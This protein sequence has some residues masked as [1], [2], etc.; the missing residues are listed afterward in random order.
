[1]TTGCCSA[2]ASAQVE[3]K[4]GVANHLHGFFWSCCD[5]KV[6]FCK[7]FPFQKPSPFSPMLRLSV[8]LLSLAE[9]GKSYSPCSVALRW[10]TCR[11][12][13]G[14]GHTHTRQHRETS[15]ESSFLKIFSL[16]LKNKPLGVALRWFGDNRGSTV[17]W[18]F[19]STPRRSLQLYHPGLCARMLGQVP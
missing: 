2:S 9:S 6:K 12:G 18:K 10:L 7:F 11:G 13:G 8:R 4:R 16:N 19:P 3:P 17:L 15:T 14:G 1:M 5:Q